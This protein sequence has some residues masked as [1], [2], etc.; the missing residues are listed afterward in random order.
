MTPR[1]HD[2]DSLVFTRVC[3]S[4]HGAPATPVTVRVQPRT[5]GLPG[6]P[7]PMRLASPWGIP[8]LQDACGA[9]WV[10]LQGPLGKR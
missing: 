10:L 9:G 3:E 5:A 4:A 8:G 2:S 7:A 1:K 6:A